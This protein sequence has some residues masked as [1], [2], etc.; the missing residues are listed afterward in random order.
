MTLYSLH[1]TLSLSHICAD[2]TPPSEDGS[3]SIS[4][5]A[6]AGIVIGVLFALFL[7]LAILWW[8]GCLTR[9]DSM[10]NGNHSANL[11]LMLYLMDV[12]LIALVSYI[13][14]FM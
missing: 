11:L 4:G 2:F 9:K 10:H 13:C 12:V 7:V 3:S 8:K 5:G 14:S 6:I 1:L